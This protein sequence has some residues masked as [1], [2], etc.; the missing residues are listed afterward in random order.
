MGQTDIGSSEASDLANQMVAYSVAAETTDAAGAQ[1]ET[2]WQTTTWTKHLGYYKTIPELKTAIDTKANW[3]VG[4]GFTADEVTT[5]LLGTIKGNG[6]DSFNSILKNQ[7]TVAKIDGDS[8]AEIIRDDDGVLV[9]LKP[10]DP[11]TIRSVQNQQGQY[12]RYEQVSKT[13]EV[14]AKFDPDDIFHLSRE[15]RA[16]EIHGISVIPAVKEIIDMR[17]EA[18]ADWRKVLHRTV[19]PVNIFYLDTDDTT[20]IAAFKA[21]MDAAKA[22]GE[23]MY[24]PKGAAEREKGGLSGNATLDPMS[25]IGQLN[26]YFF[27]AVGVPQVIVGNAKAF[28]DASAKIVYLA[29]EQNVKAEQLYIE[30]QVLDQLNVEIHLTFPASLQSEA[31]SD[32]PNPEEMPVEEE[33]MEG[34]AQPNDTTSEMEGKK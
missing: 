32:S 23:N 13:K 20:E 3:I 14:L 22:K 5:L 19:Y 28:T 11:S 29:F 34:A 8:Y 4:A 17:N 2:T 7:D 24:I 9:N 33:G 1:K 18:M 25:W 10:L 27:Q 21:K 31:I 6:K 12:I 15:R 30:E 26:D 16:D